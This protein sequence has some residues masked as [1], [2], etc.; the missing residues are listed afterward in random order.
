MLLSLEISLSFENTYPKISMCKEIYSSPFSGV[1]TF[2]D[3]EGTGT[4]ICLGALFCSD[5]PSGP[6]C[7]YRAVGGNDC[8]EFPHGVV[9]HSV[10]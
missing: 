2:W 3:I 4:M 8:D 1:S 6:D 7:H 9:H 5:G 10:L